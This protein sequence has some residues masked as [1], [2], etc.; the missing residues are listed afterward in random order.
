MSRAERQIAEFKSWR[1]PYPYKELVRLLTHLGYEESATAGGSR[2]RFIHATSKH[3]IRLHEPHPGTEV[4]EYMV[5]QVR[6]ALSE[7]G[8]I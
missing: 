1:G 6:T 3:V 7:Q 4:L 2:R 8:L 5:K